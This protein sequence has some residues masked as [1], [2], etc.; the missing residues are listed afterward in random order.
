[1]LQTQG[2]GPLPDPQRYLNDDSP[3]GN[4]LMPGIRDPGPLE[5]DWVV[6]PPPA[7]FI[8]I[9]AYLTEAR[10]GRLMFGVGVNSNAG[11]IGNIV[12]SE[13]NFD[14]LNP[15]TSWNDLWNGNAWRG[16]GQ[17]FRI[18]ALPGTQV[19]RYMVDWQDPYFLDSDY[20]LGVSGFYYNRYFRYWTE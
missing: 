16:A 5:N 4:P 2:R 15:P 17:K 6:P 18:E 8:D 7:D 1:I 11:L 13:N 9:D 3:Q 19:S 12:F 20:N 10:T 14:I